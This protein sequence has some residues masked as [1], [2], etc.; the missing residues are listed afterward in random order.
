MMTRWETESRFDKLLNYGNI[1]TDLE[2]YGNCFQIACGLASNSGS[3]N[4]QRAVDKLNYAFDV[5]ERCNVALART[6]VPVVLPS[7]S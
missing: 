5:C 3:T 6:S 2:H 4:L 7:N 1:L